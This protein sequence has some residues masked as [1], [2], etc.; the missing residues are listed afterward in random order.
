MSLNNVD[1][2][3]LD[4]GNDAFPAQAR[5]WSYQSANLENAWV[6]SIEKVYVS[7]SEGALSQ[8]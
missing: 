3:R 6:F 5:I 7:A 8:V 1:V 4:V 2:H